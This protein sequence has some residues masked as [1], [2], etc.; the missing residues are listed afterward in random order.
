MM[1]ISSFKKWSEKDRHAVRAYNHICI[2][3]L[4]RTDTNFM[5]ELEKDLLLLLLMLG[6]RKFPI[7]TIC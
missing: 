1:K 3:T 6:V 7:F 2:N 4:I 5:L